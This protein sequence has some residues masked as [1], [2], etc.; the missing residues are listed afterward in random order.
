MNPKDFLIHNARLVLRDR[1]IE[2]GWIAVA[3]R[4]IA[5]IGDGAAPESGLDAG[6]AT[7]A[8]GLVELH[9]DHLEL[10]YTPR[11]A[12]KWPALSAVLAYDAQIAASG[13]TT[14][15]DSLRAGLEDRRDAV[16]SSLDVLA[17][18]IDEAREK[19]LLRV[20]HLTHLRCELST[21]DVL[22]VTERF[23]TKRPVHL[24]SLMD[25]TPGQRQFQDIEKFLV[26]YRGK[27][28]LT[29]EQLQALI[30]RRLR[31]HALRAGPNRRRLVDIARDKGIALAS[32]DDATAEHVA[33]SL[34]D[35]V[36]I[37]EF[38]TTLE[39]AR[40]SHEAGIGVLMGAP[41]LVRGG[42]HSGNVA[43]ED[44]ARQGTLDI[45]SSDY[46]PASLLQAAFDLPR[47]V[48]SISLPDALATVT[49]NPARA[50]GL[51]DRG[52]LEPGLR[53]DLVCLTEGA[54]PA[55]RA[56]WR[57]GLRVV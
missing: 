18:A 10:H 27:T 4:R 20:E 3:D 37:A 43:A 56:V 19:D 16:T 7:L 13:I 54:V 49:D 24:M 39:A 40:A 38:P 45:F 11:P 28:N 26:Y 42:S 5:E 6:G 31:D 23:L 34:A 36:S 35:G 15:F 22:E 55:V 57:E 25:H 8:P 51:N 1:V 44:L 46:V 21:E 53:A 32:H 2:Q 50:A 48:P 12:V 47:R 41:N 9:T 52:R 30:E 29:E 14:V 17:E 33:E